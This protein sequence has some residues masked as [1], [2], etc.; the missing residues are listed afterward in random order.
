MYEIL[1]LRQIQF[2]FETKSPPLWGGI[3]IYLYKYVNG[4]LS[5]NY[6]TF[7][8]INE[9][10]KCLGISRE[11]IRIFLNTYVPF[12]NNLFLTDLIEYTDIAEK[13]ISDATQGLELDRT[14]AKKV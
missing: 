2:N 9:L 11:T 13:L 4:E 12:R 14:I 8:S 7:K 3:K 1:K 10:S 6:G 5:T